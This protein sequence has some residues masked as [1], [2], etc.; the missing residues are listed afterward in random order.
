M[1]PRPP[2]RRPVGPTLRPPTLESLGDPL[3]PPLPYIHP[4]PPVEHP[5]GKD[6]EVELREYV[7]EMWVQQLMPIRTCCFRCRNPSPIVHIPIGAMMFGAHAKRGQIDVTKQAIEAFA[8]AGW[9]FQ[10]RKSYCPDC[11]NLGSV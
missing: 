4:V 11:K 6:P 2:Q 8:K 10:L 5:Y 3:R 1:R 7:D 9:K